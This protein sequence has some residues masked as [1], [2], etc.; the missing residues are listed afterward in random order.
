MIAGTRSSL[1]GQI[2]RG[3]APSHGSRLGPDAPSASDGALLVDGCKLPPHVLPGL[4]RQERRGRA[5]LQ[6]MRYPHRLARAAGGPPERP[7]QEAAPSPVAAAPDP[8]PA[9]AGSAAAASAAAVPE[10]SGPRAV[11]GRGGTMVL[12]SKQAVAA[13]APEVAQAAAGSPSQS[14]AAGAPAPAAPSEDVWG[15]AR[16]R[17]GRGGRRASASARLPPV[18]RQ[19]DDYE[20]HP[21]LHR[22]SLP[23]QGVGLVA[24]HRLDSFCVRRGGDVVLASTFG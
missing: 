1:E 21:R 20:R 15:G 9:A 23:D 6:Q 22:H 4:W 19:P 12:G 24:N 17:W 11:A 8:A 10:A 14:A 3:G 2:D 16:R 5:I 18:G 7:S 13:G